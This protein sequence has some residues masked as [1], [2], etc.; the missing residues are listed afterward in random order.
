MKEQRVLCLVL[1][2]EGV[3]VNNLHLV[4]NCMS[5][6]VVNDKKKNKLF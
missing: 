6:C 2:L 1:H 3:I 5:E 4:E